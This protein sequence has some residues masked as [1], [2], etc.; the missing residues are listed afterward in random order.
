[1]KNLLKRKLSTPVARGACDVVAKLQQAGYQALVV[2][3][4]VRD[5]LLDREPKDYDIATNATPEEVKR[6]FR[7]RGR[8][9]GRRF[10][11]VHVYQNGMTYEVST[12]R[13]TPTEE[14]RKG[15][16]DDD[17]IMVWRDNVYG[18]LEDD[19]FRRDFTVNALYLDPLR[20]EDGVKDFVNGLEDIQNAYVRTIG[21]TQLRLHEDPVR[22][23]RALKLMGQYSFR[24]SDELEAALPEA[25]PKIQ[26]ASKL[27][28]LEE[29]FK[30]L[31]RQ[32]SEPTFSVFMDYG[33][34]DYLFP[35]LA[36]EWRSSRGRDVRGLLAE[37]DRLLK[38][39][40]IFPSRI[41]GVAIMLIPRL[42]EMLNDGSS[43]FW[44]NFNGIDKILQEEI[45]RFMTPYP[46]PRHVVAKIRDVLLLLPKLVAAK[47]RKRVVRHPEYERGKD[48]LTLL[49]HYYDIDQG[50]LDYWPAPSE[51]RRGRKRL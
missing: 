33:L 44:R 34:M 45:R 13:R 23:L 12:F 26:K 27:R 41:T 43:L 16:P 15:R 49:A 6:V 1:M 30:I 18:T 24:L 32:W 19:A 48:L 20:L 39:E 35:G 38:E 37:R 25:M 47:N 22:V 17:G 46:I 11:L 2:G 14:E 42:Q 40:K 51:K 31:R 4:A 8:I 7:K 50:I 29:I 3:G 10:K 21:D 36:E 9:I 5:L 28:L